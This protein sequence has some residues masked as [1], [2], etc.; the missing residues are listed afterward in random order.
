MTLQAQYSLI[1]RDLEREHVP[2]CRKH[3]VGILPWAPLA[4]GFLTGKIDKDQ[5]PPPGTRLAKFRE[6]LPGYDTPRHWRTL[7]AVKAVAR[8][9]S[10]SPSASMPMVRSYRRGLTSEPTAYCRRPPAGVRGPGRGRTSIRSTASGRAS[11]TRESSLREI[12]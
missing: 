10:P 3:G 1:M 6:R 2:L 11:M 9:P 5:P 4:A 7:A 12:R 8:R